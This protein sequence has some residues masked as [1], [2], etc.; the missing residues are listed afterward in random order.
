MNNKI[1]EIL[2]RNRIKVDK[3]NI[4]FF[5]KIGMDNVKDNIEFYFDKSFTCESVIQELFI[6]GITEYIKN[7]NFSYLVK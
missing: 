4:E 1:N 3:F 5:H 6:R 2:V 7:D